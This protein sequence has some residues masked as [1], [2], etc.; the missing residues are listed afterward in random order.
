MAEHSELQEVIQ[1]VDPAW[2]SLGDSQ[3]FKES[4]TLENLQ[5]LINDIVSSLLNLYKQNGIYGIWSLDTVFVDHSGRYHLLPEVGIKTV[6]KPNQFAFY[7]AFAAYEL[8]TPD[9]DWPIGQ[10]SDVYGLGMLLRTLILKVEPRSA[11]SRMEYDAPLAAHVGLTIPPEAL[12]VIDEATQVAIADRI[13]TV[14]EFVQLLN[15]ASEEEDSTGASTDDDPKEA[16]AAIPPVPANTQGNSRLQAFINS[17]DSDW[18]SLRDG[19]LVKRQVTLEDLQNLV[20]DIYP[21]LLSV[22]ERGGIYGVWS[23]DTVFVDPIGRFHLVPDVGVR[24]V[25]SADQSAVFPEYAAYELTTTDPD[26]PIGP[27][28][29]VYGIGMIMRTLILKTPPLTPRERLRKDFEPLSK[30]H[31]PSLS[32]QVLRV[33][34]MALAFKISSR[35]STVA[36]LLQLLNTLPD[37][38]N[39]YIPGSTLKFPE[40]PPAQ[41]THFLGES[42]E[43]EAVPKA[44]ATT[45]VVASPKESPKAS[46]KEKPKGPSELELLAAQQPAPPKRKKSKA[47]LMLP[48]LIVLGVGGWY[49]YNHAGKDYAAQVAGDNPD[50]TPSDI[51]D[52]DTPAENADAQAPADMAAEPDSETDSGKPAEADEAEKSPKTADQKSEQTDQ[53]GSASSGPNGSVAAAKIAKRAEQSKE[54]SADKDAK[55]KKLADEKAK[56][57]KAKQD[58]AKADKLAK[59]QK[60]AQEAKAKLAKEEKAA[61][62]AKAKAEKAARE[63]KLAK[64]AEAARKAQEAAAAREAEAKAK[65]EEAARKS[66]ELAE[67]ERQ[68]KAAA[69]QPAPQQPIQGYRVTGATDG[70]SSPQPAPKSKSQALDSAIPSSPSARQ[71]KSAANIVD[72]TGVKPLLLPEKPDPKAAQAAQNKSLAQNGSGTISFNI[73]PW[74][75]VKI[76]GHA[77]GASPP[78]RQ[79]RLKAGNYRV[80]VDNGRGAPVTYNVTV[81][82]GGTASVSHQF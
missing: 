76:D 9:H 31:H 20:N 18:Q 15:A 21:T 70:P 11:R 60:A 62:E 38:S 41:P 32:R 57:E 16:D 79:V 46:Q 52:E 64:D 10:Y 73:S 3:L 66:A 19:P 27:H 48:L 54:E 44:P 2:R 1:S 37:Y 7:P 56:A 58:K 5:D 30:Q 35:I 55:A 65:A 14:P 33:I 81:T 17:V 8:T 28:T 77:Y 42:K 63:A 69:P 61:K 26:W 49:F 39:Q 74:G 24:T 22:Y 40:E 50:L 71:P 34:D 25:K 53:S 67:L 6:K 47:W 80:Q 75:N 13:Q 4:V 12:R 72:Q 36:E 45:K 59:E 78:I 68:R 23:L 82:P 29:D 43:E 51:V